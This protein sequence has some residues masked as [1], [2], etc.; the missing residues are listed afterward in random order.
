MLSRARL[1]GEALRYALVQGEEQPD[2]FSIQHPQ[3]PNVERPKEKKRNRFFKVDDKV[4]FY[5][6]ISR[7]IWGYEATHLVESVIKGLFGEVEACKSM[8]PKH[9]AKHIRGKGHELK[10]A[11][12]YQQLVIYMTREM[13]ETLKS[14]PEF[15]A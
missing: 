1:Y 12:K 15:V 6:K 2:F 13:Y 5:F 10:E 11:E 14:H 4:H 7:P 3:I 8:A 9:V